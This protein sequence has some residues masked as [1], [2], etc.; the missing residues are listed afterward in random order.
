MARLLVLLATFAAVIWLV[1]AGVDFPVFGPSFENIVRGIRSSADKAKYVEII[2]G[3]PGSR[4]KYFWHGQK[5]T[6]TYFHKTRYLKIDGPH[7]LLIAEGHV[8]R[9]SWVEPCVPQQTVPQ[10]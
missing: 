4:I 8:S 5:F 7:D 3:K 6:A 1:A 9:P 2:E 10:K